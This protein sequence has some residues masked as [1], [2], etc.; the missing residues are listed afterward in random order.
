MKIIDYIA[1]SDYALLVFIIIVY[2]L[3][4]IFGYSIGFD[5]GLREPVCL[6]DDVFVVR[7]I[8]QT[9]RSHYKYTLEQAGKIF[10]WDSVQMYNLGDSLR[11]NK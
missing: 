9:E 4:V 5:A 11:I 6:C 8:E 3:M 1:D 2:I 10:K 7:G